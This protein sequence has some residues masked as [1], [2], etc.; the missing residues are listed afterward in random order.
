[1]Y[2]GNF[3]CLEST[4]KPE[5]VGGLHEPQTSL[6]HVHKSNHFNI[7][8]LPH[9]CSIYLCN[10]FNLSILQLCI[11]VCMCVCCWVRGHSN[12]SVEKTLQPQPT[13]CSHADSHTLSAIAHSSPSLCCHIKLDSRNL[14][15]DWM[16][17]TWYEVLFANVLHILPRG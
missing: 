17:C 13:T 16:F 3:T 9:T 11:C 10:L 14:Q 8:T 7:G 15:C 12:D 4:E 5:T 6:D 2:G 1:M